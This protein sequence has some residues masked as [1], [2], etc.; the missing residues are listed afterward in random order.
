MEFVLAMRATDEEVD[1]WLAQ[2]EA[3]YALACEH[4]PAAHRRVGALN[5]LEF[6]A[7]L[8]THRRA[9]PEQPSHAAQQQQSFPIPLGRGLAGCCS[10]GLADC[11]PEG[12]DPII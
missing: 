6:S 12:R 1:I 9:H 10:I 3:L 2:A 7:D 4:A 8:E 11:G 5:G